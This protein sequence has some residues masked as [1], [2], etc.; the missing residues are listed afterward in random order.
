MS[1]KAILFALVVTTVVTHPIPFFH[2]HM[3]ENNVLEV[4]PSEDVSVLTTKPVITV[5][6]KS[7]IL[8][9]VA[10]T[11]NLDMLEIASGK[12]EQQIDRAINGVVHSTY[13]T[14]VTQ[15]MNGEAVSCEMTLIREDKTIRAVISRGVF[16]AP[17]LAQEGVHVQT[18]VSEFTLP[19]TEVESSQ[20][21]ENTAT[22]LETT[23]NTL[24]SSS[25]SS[26]RGLKEGEEPA[27]PGGEKKEKEPFIDRFT[28]GINKIADTWKNVASAFRS[29]KTNTMIEQMPSDGFDVFKRKSRFVK[30][31][32]IP[33]AMY[34]RFMVGWTAFTGMVQS[35]Y[36]SEVKG[37]TEMAEF[38]DNQAFNI[39][40][41]NF[42]KDKGGEID[43]IVCISA[44]DM[45]EMKIGIA[46][47]KVTGSFKLSPNKFL[48]AKSK[49]TMGG[50][51]AKSEHYIKQE[52]RDITEKDI[53]AIHH[54]MILATLETMTQGFGIDFK[55]P[56]A[57]PSQI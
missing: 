24:L 21:D 33:S 34:S 41:F 17:M 9:E 29:E 5:L 45:M 56:T 38:V 7:H 53:T 8:N 46:T 36:W 13:H 54:L 4:T 28:G 6:A 20:F 1:I 32:G 14:H 39:N 44:A 18:Y 42:D 35:K 48:W 47:V 10:K 19:F 52:A 43:T 57:N 30:A 12:I 3:I 49:S 31:I 25:H 22:F 2:D 37:L 23:K 27:P 50:I 11:L 51:S 55:L 16:E 15:I 26:T 40:D